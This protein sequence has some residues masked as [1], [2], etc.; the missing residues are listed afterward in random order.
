MGVFNKLFFS[1]RCPHCSYVGRLY[2]E[3]KFGRLNFD[4]YEVDDDVL[5]EGPG[6]G[7]RRFDRPVTGYLA[8]YGYAVCPRCDKSWWVWVTIENNR[9]Q[10]VEDSPGPEPFLE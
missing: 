9:F 4:N 5:W 3:V 1:G 6:E 10:S 2:A 7:L 8:D